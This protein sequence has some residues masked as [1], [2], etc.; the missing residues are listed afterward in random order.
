M[1]IRL[2]SGYYSSC[3]IFSIKCQILITIFKWIRVTPFDSLE[4]QNYLYLSGIIATPSN[5]EPRDL[6]VCQAFQK[7]DVLS[8]KC[9]SIISAAF[10]LA[11]TYT[12]KNIQVK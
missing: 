11:S 1:Q 5:K 12:W 3:E 4:S 6:K 8:K 2:I 9:C 7:C 10:H